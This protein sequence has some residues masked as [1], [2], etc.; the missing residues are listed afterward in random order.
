MLFLKLA[1][2]FPLA[3]S[4]E[5]I[6]SSYDDFNNGDFNKGAAKLSP[7][8][9]RGSISK[10]PPVFRPG[11][12]KTTKEMEGAILPLPVYQSRHTRKPFIPS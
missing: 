9:L 2:S 5:Q 6:L 1:L 10:K 7:A 12:S 4:V 11:V 8:F 3:S